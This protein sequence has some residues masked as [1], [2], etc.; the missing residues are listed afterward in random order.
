MSTTLTTKNRWNSSRLNCDSSSDSNSSTSSQLTKPDRCFHKLKKTSKTCAIVLPYLCIRKDL[1]QKCLAMYSASS[2]FFQQ[3]FSPNTL[4]CF[5]KSL[6]GLQS[7]Q[8]CLQACQI[9]N[10]DEKHAWVEF[11][12]VLPILKI[13]T[14]IP[15]PQQCSIILYRILSHLELEALPLFRHQ[16]PVSKSLKT[17]ACLRVP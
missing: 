14:A 2:S 10:W 13:V 4:S 3:R 7:A 5:G 15:F 9:R 16:K 1:S 12:R 11:H 17:R 8:N 6:R